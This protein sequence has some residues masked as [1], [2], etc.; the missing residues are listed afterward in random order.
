LWINYI[1][2]GRQQRES[3]GSTNKKLAHKILISRKAQLLE[4]RWSLPRS[5]SP[6]L[7]DSS[8]EFLKAKAHEKTRSRYQSSVNNLLGH[9]GHRIRLADI[10]PPMYPASIG[11]AP[12][13]DKL[14]SF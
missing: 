5:H 7:G 3:T 13:W 2:N 6:R 12:G 14:P 4:E 1:R 10:T 9:L 11:F 8:K